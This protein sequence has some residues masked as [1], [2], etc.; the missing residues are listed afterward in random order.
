MEEVGAVARHYF[1]RHGAHA[2]ML[3]EDQISLATARSGWGDA[4]T[5]YRIRER[6]QRLQQVKHA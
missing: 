2:L 4:L 5:W 6:F 1:D 3:I